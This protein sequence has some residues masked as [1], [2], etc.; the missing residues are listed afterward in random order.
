MSDYGNPDGKE[1][2]DVAIEYSPLHN[3]E[4]SAEA[5]R[6]QAL[7]IANGDCQPV[8]YPATLVVTAD[9]DDRVA[10][11]HSL[12]YIAELQY[13]FQDST[14][15]SKPLMARIETKAGH[16][17]GKPVSKQVGVPPRTS[18]DYFWTT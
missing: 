6:Q 7:S 2:F 16:G 1:D 11:L 14:R 10:P 12:K 5:C 8:Q 15:Q 4:Q 9:H 13:R 3:I 17:A 18:D